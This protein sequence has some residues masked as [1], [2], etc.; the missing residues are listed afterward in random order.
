MSKTSTLPVDNIELPEMVAYASQTE[1]LF[2]MMD[3]IGE[4][5]KLCKMKGFR[6]LASILSLARYE[7]ERQ[8]GVYNED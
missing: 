8:Q 2:Y 5:E 7:A 1:I 3:L 4:L 6:T